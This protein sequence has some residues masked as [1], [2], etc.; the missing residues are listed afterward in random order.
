MA[1]T[2]LVDW[3]IGFPKSIFNRKAVFSTLRGDVLYLQY[4]EK[5]R[6]VPIFGKTYQEALGPIFPFGNEGLLSA[7]VE[8]SVILSRHH[9]HANAGRCSFLQM[10]GFFADCASSP[11]NAHA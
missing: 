9:P 2:F 6:S 3:Q 4:F 5:A 11:A 10:S 7:G 8:V 1:V